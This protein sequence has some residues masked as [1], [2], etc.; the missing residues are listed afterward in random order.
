MEL[1]HQ[2]KLKEACGV[3]GIYDPEGDL[4]HIPFTWG[5]MPCSTAA[6]NPAASQSATQ[7]IEGQYQLP[8][9]HGACK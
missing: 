9:G 7:K 1:L 6:R 8:P 2:D 5:S 3:F 4:R